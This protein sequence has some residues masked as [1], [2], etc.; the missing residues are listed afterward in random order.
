MLLRGRDDHGHFDIVE[1]PRCDMAYGESATHT[2]AL[3]RK[4]RNLSKS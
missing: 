3:A 2:E 1:P 4:V